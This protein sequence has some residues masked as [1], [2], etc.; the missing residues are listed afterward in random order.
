M[1]LRQRS[2]RCANTAGSK[3]LAD[4]TSGDDTSHSSSPIHNS[5]SLSESSKWTGCPTWQFSSCSHRIIIMTN[6]LLSG[7]RIGH[8]KVSS[9]STRLYVATFG[10]LCKGLN[11][12]TA[13]AHVQ[14]F[15]G[16]TAADR[17]QLL[18]RRR[19]III[20]DYLVP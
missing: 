3:P 12:P 13:V 2:Y 1:R 5:K 15:L 17:F 7:S 19:P 20:F 14:N 18:S 6:S 11:E 8:W 9:S 4:P 16:Y 10:H